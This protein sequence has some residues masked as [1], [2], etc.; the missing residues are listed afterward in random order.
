MREGGPTFICKLQ[1]VVYNETA[2]EPYSGGQIR[3][4]RLARVR[5]SSNVLERMISLKREESVV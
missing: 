1:Q 4:I 2:C 5:S 3:G